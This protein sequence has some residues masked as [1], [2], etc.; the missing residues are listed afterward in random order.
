VQWHGFASANLYA[1]R[2]GQKTRYRVVGQVFSY[3]EPDNKSD[4]IAESAKCV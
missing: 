3:C 4:E 1:I 2:G